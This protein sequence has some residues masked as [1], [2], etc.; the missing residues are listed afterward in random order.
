VD[1]VESLCSGLSQKIWQK[2]TIL[3]QFLSRQKSALPVP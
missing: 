1:Q 2:I 3:D